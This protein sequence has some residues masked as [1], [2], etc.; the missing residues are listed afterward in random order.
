MSIFG[1]SLFPK[2]RHPRSELVELSSKK[3]DGVTKV[4]DVSPWY[5]E[6]RIGVNKQQPKVT[7]T[8]VEAFDEGTY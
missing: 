2:Y 4:D 5:I 8:V 1:I 6:N 7:S 3:H